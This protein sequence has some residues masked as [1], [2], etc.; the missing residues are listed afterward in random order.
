MSKRAWGAWF[1]FLLPPREWLLPVF[2]LCGAL[3]GVVLVL[4]RISNATAYL[5]EDPRACINCH[6]MFPQYETWKHSSHYQKASC[7]DCHVPHDSLARKYYFKAQDGLRHSTIFTMRTEPQV[8]RM[9]KAGQ[10]VV[11]ENCIRCHE[12]L[13]DGT[14]LVHGDYQQYLAGDAKLCWECHREVPHGRVKSL[15]ATPYF[16]VPV[17]SDPLPQPMK[18]LREYLEK[19]TS[20]Q[21]EKTHE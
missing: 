1:S 13:V 17:L 4:L 3:V 16:Q 15:A 12:Q 11:Q 18:P 2:F 21:E 5:S 6:V 8:I 7:T 19:L 9:H 14:D 20:P 10:A